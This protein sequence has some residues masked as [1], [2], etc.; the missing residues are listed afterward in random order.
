MMYYKVRP[1][2]DNKPRYTINAK[3]RIV[4]DSILVA[5]ELYTPSEFGRIKNCKECFEK[6]DISKSRVYFCF[7]ARFEME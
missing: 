4:C 6:V 3:G 5:N 7:G 1:E 2:Y